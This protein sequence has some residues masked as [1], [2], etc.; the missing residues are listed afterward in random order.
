VQE[1]MQGII[2]RQQEL[3]HR[4]LHVMRAVDGAE[5]R[6]AASMGSG[7]SQVV[8]RIHTHTHT[9]THTQLGYML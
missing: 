2:R 1:R 4:L 7:F 9:H 5:G 3:C 8:T 6:L